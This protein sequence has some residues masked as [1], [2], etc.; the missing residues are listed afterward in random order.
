M[1]ATGSQVVQQSH[2]CGIKEEMAKKG[3]KVAAIESFPQQSHHCGI[4][5]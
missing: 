4:E 1:I 2:H 5:K 3:S